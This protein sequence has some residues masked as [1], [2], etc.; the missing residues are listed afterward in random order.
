[1]PMREIV[2]KDKA[3]AEAS[4]LLIFPKKVA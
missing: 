3:L 4:A 2:R 1:M